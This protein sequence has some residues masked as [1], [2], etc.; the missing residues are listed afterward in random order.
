MFT[1]SGKWLVCAANLAA[2]LTL[3][4]VNSDTTLTTLNEHHETDNRYCQQTDGNQGE[5]VDIT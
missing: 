4:V 1:F 3:G 5:D 2:L